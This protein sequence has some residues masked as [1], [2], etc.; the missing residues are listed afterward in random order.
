MVFPVTILGL[1]AIRTVFQ[2]H[3]GEI[4]GPVPIVISSF[5]VLAP[6]GI[7]IGVCFSAGAR[8]MRT[9]SPVPHA[10]IGHVYVLEALGSGVAG[11]LLHFIMERPGRFWRG[12]KPDGHGNERTGCFS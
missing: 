6:I 4:V 3:P 10:G 11:A 8:I 5:S 7:L 1:R 9:F 2:F 12:A